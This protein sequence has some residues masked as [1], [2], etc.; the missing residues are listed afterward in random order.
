M[1]TIVD[2]FCD[3]RFLR[4]ILHR[5]RN[6]RCEILWEVNLGAKYI[7]DI[8]DLVTWR[9]YNLMLKN[10]DIYIIT[11][12]LKVETDIITSIAATSRGIAVMLVIIYR[13]SGFPFAGAKFRNFLPKCLNCFSGTSF[14]R[15][16]VLTKIKF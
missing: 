10:S 9:H 8:E 7:N 15:S 3:S 12:N 2:L 14:S 13:I 16:R 1:Y 6:M 5:R 11:S 4:A